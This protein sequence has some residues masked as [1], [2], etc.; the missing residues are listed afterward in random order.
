[1]A[2]FFSEIAIWILSLGKYFIISDI[3]W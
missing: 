2:K 1:L 3:C